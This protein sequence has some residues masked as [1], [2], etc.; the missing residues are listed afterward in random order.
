MRLQV[1]FIVSFFW[2][3]TWCP[4]LSADSGLPLALQATL[5]SKLVRYDRSLPQEIGSIKVLILCK[6]SS[7]TAEELKNGLLKVGI[8]AEV[9]PI[10]EL[11]TR[12]GAAHVLYLM[13]D[14][15]PEQAM[16]F[17]ETNKVLSV[18]GV[19][20]LAE[21]GRVSVAFAEGLNHKPEIVVHLARLGIE[22]QEL[23]SAFL[24]IA[25]VIR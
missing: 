1:A 8:Q 18:A 24:G 12:A 16:D 14:V 10:A 13:P 15:S 2:V 22:K 17:A 3:T 20:E 9:I 6:Q 25:R 4:W 5:I 19:A 21:E 23:T 7:P 11:H